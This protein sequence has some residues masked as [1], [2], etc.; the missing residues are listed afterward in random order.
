MDRVVV[1]VAVVEAGGDWWCWLWRWWGVELE[2]KYIY[3]K[4][5]Q[6]S[7]SADKARRRGGRRGVLL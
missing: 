4:G 5:E 3:R 1:L 6:R 2:K 7:D